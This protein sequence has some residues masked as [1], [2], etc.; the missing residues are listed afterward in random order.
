MRSL[1]AAVLMLFGSLAHAAYTNVNVANACW[2]NNQTGCLAA[3]AIVGCTSCT[4]SGTG[5]YTGSG[6]SWGSVT[7]SCTACPQGY[8]R[9]V[10]SGQCELPPPPECPPGSTLENEVCTCPAGQSIGYAGTVEGGL[11]EQCIDDSQPP[12][13]CDGKTIIGTYNGQ[14]VCDNLENACPAGYNPGLVNGELYCSPII[15]N[16]PNCPDGGSYGT[17]GGVTACWDPEPNI[18]DPD[19][20]P[21]QDPNSPSYPGPDPSN[22]TYPNDPN[23]PSPN[24]PNHTPAPEPEPG[25]FD[26]SRIIGELSKLN[27]KASVTNEKLDTANGHLSD[28]ADKLGQGGDPLPAHSQAT[29]ASFGE[30]NTAFTTRVGSSALVSSF[31]GM[32]NL[33]S[34]DGAECPEFSIDFPAPIDSTVS[35]IIHC[36]LMALISPYLSAIM[37][38]VFSFLA[39]RIFA[40]S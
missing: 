6:N 21:N 7:A 24:N 5:C 18:N 1:L 12:D 26:D 22:P 39:F 25:D 35:T 9:S 34:T 23:W 33:V 8:E 20:P 28:I 32:K 10:E 14:P 13:S 27:S 15:D 19:Y 30:V 2:T 37:F 16:D 11:A 36:E 31:S 3:A 38:A 29:A 40:S 17:V 4:W